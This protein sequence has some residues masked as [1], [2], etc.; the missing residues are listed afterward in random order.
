MCEGEMSAEMGTGKGM[1]R[2]EALKG[3][4]EHGGP[5]SSET[6]REN[7]RGK[8]TKLL[9]FLYAQNSSERKITFRFEPKN[10]F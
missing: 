9:F 7:G 8:L 6:G 2:S 3:G 10:F 4:R 1:N 5:Q